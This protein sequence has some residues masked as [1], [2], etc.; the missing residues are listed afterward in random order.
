M[1]K[2]NSKS[3]GGKKIKNRNSSPPPLVL[4]V[5]ELEIKSQGGS[6]PKKDFNLELCIDK[7]KKSIYFG[8]NWK[9][10]FSSLPSSFDSHFSVGRQIEDLLERC[11]S[12][13]E[14]K[15]EDVDDNDGLG[16]EVMKMT[17][18]SQ[19][20]NGSKLFRCFFRVD[21]ASSYQRRYGHQRYDDQK[22]TVTVESLEKFLKQFQK[23]WDKW[24]AKQEQL[25]HEHDTEDIGTGAGT[26]LKSYG[27]IRQNGTNGT[28]T[29]TRPTSAFSSPFPTKRSIRRTSSSRKKQKVY[30]RSRQS[31]FER[32]LDL[33]PSF[34]DEDDYHYNNNNSNNNNRN[35]TSLSSTSPIPPRRNDDPDQE[36]PDVCSLNN[37][38]MEVKVEEE[39]PIVQNKSKSKSTSFLP[40][41]SVKKRRRRIQR[42]NASTTLIDN[43]SEDDIMFDT[44]ATT[45]NSALDYDI[46]DDDDEM[47][48]NG[49]EGEIGLV[50]K[51]NHTKLEMKQTK[52]TRMMERLP[53]LVSPP[54][55]TSGRTDSDTKNEVRE[56]GE[57]EHISDA[58]TDDSIEDAVAGVDEA[59]EGDDR[60][61]DLAAVQTP[62]ITSFFQPKQRQ[63]VLSSND[64]ILDVKSSPTRASTSSDTPPPLVHKDMNTSP[65]S[66]TTPSKSK[67][68]SKNH[69]GTKILSSADR[70]LNMPSRKYPKIIKSPLITTSSSART[71]TSPATEMKSPTRRAI[72]QNPYKERSTHVGLRNLGN[73]CYLNSSLQMIFSVPDFVRSLQD[74]Y[75]KYKDDISD[76]GD[77]T[78]I[79]TTTTSMPLTRAFLKVAMDAKIIAPTVQKTHESDNNSSTITSVTP[80][81]VKEAIDVLTDKFKGYEQ[82]DAHEFVSTLIDYIHD[83][84]VKVTTGTSIKE[85]QVEKVILPTDEFF[86]LNVKVC[87]TCDSC[88]Y[89]RYVK[90]SRPSLFYPAYF[91]KLTMKIVSFFSIF[92][93]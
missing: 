74:I 78:S 32:D 75:N 93:L 90:K 70:A 9:I 64:D 61:E 57:E 83:E 15:E 42:S 17:F 51:S 21:I 62:S 7:T 58:I 46:D 12:I 71:N 54:H 56:R 1:K 28:F 92:L 14:S 55:Q 66:C 27:R 60:D 22:V 82:R 85:Q 24:E 29:P 76:V 65:T 52:G 8:P 31:N 59:G 77:E 2:K 87:L 36:E 84:L 26:H 19:S 91:H 41:S 44:S 37:E 35:R 6:Q 86:R 43:D 68:F 34:D 18:Q 53:V 67:Y 79:T 3:P 50:E 33:M 49:K 48:Q 39:E 13:L 81:E 5:N 38:D 72:I 4:P 89:S 80:R 45:K 69:G 40:P 47:G 16:Y 23:I 63:Q 11:R 10:K 30:G 25:Q 73:T 20:K 88:K